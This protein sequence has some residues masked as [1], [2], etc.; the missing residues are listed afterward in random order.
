MKQPMKKAALAM[1]CAGGM[2]VTMQAEATNWLMLQ[3]TERDSAA[4]RAKVWGFI[5]ATYLKTAG[6]K[7]PVQNGAAG[8]YG[9]QDPQFE[10]HQPNLAS[11]E[12]F[13]MQRA[14]IGVRGAGM[15]ID[16]KVNYFIMAEYGN[17]GITAVGGGSSSVK[18]ADASITL[19]HI[20]GMRVRLGQMKIPMAE[21]VYQGIVTFNYINL[22]N[23]ANQ[24]F[25]ER[26]F[27]T[28][29]RAACN[30]LTTTNT[31]DGAITI[32]KSSDQYLQYCNGNADVQFRSSAG[33]VRDTGIQLFDSFNTG[34]WETSYALLYGN[35]GINKDNRDN[36]FDTS[37]Y[38]STEKVFGGSKGPRRQG[39][40]FYA[41]Q[42]EGKRTIYDSA[43]L[44]AGITTLEAAERT[45]DRKLS[46]FGLT[47]L[48]GKYRFWAELNKADGMIFNGST[49]GAVPGAIN[50]ASTGPTATPTNGV[51][52]PAGTQVSQF[53]LA[54][55]GKAD[56]GYIDFG[57]KVMP[58]LELDL[59]YDWYNRVTNAGDPNGFGGFYPANGTAERFYSTMTYGV[60]YFFNK[61]T[62]LIVNYE[63][64][65]FDS[66]NHP[67]AAPPNNVANTMSNKLSAQVMAIF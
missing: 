25:I 22:T 40:K 30:I 7:L 54:P 2:L 67:A 19:N 44:N 63:V 3:G 29:G 56:G 23:M 38:L 39:L 13:Q 59:R 10:V 24:Q 66:P 42:T 28:D 1:A 57:Y 18:L 35:G 14:R 53:L 49:G 50:S 20:K 62:R 6:N 15:P 12:T 46:G 65:D 8:L 47:Y 45:F 26:P 5:Q 27:W 41:W 36:D 32:N 17:N 16:P 4:G 51:G 60:Q 11:S 33:A 52:I 31:V 61:K 64:R 48:R 34:G 21:E 43:L 58:K 9:G 55:E 37:V